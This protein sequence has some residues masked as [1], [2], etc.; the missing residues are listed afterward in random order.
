MVRVTTN[1]SPRLG[2]VMVVSDAGVVLMDPFSA[3]RALPP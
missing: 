3:G 1:M 2:V